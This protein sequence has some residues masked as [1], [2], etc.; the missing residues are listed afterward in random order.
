MDEFWSS[1]PEE[2]TSL[3]IWG[4]DAEVPIDHALRD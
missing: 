1:G 3:K 4:S 2:W